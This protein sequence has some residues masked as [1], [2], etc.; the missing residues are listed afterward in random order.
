MDLQGYLLV[1]LGLFVM[2]VFMGLCFLLDWQNC[3]FLVK[4]G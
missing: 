4:R 2:S 1:L 3:F